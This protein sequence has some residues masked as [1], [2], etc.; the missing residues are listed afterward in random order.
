MNKNNQ[1]N[2]NRSE[3]LAFTGERLVKGEKILNP[4]RV[5]NLARFNFFKE[6]L[7]E[8]NILDFGC[9][10]GEGSYFLSSQVDFSIIG[11]DIAFD[12]VNYAKNIYDQKKLSFLCG[13][14]IHP[15][16][17]KNHFKN[18]ISVEVIEHIKDPM[19]YLENVRDLITHDGVFMLTTP[20]QRLSSPTKESLWPDH[21]KEYDSIELKMLC[22]QYFDEVQIFGEFIP[23]YEKNLIR[24]T[25]RKVSKIIKPLLPK[26]VRVRALPFLFYLIKSDLSINE[27]K[28]TSKN[29]ET[30]PTL[31]AVCKGPKNGGNY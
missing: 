14:I 8:G 16:F 6:F 7:I 27:I 26:W 19:Q 4:L 17:E 20:N 11:V 1:N 15:C 28:F 18:I 2:L 21:V 12:A 22:N 13:D 24:K 9:G 5:E 10:S 29:I 30:C 23:V 31:V 3:D 25:V